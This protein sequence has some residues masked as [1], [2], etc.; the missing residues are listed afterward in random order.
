ML[1]HL[2]HCCLSRWTQT[3]SH[4][5][6][7]KPLVVNCQEQCENPVET[8]WFLNGLLLAMFLESLPAAPQPLMA[9][10]AHRAVSTPAKSQPP[11]AREEL[12]RFSTTVEQMILAHITSNKKTPRWVSWML[13]SCTWADPSVFN[14]SLNSFFSK[15]ATSVGLRKSSDV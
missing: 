10:W 4:W 13:R 12:R 8:M 15:C 1:A 11:L 3:K 14:H 6:C 9:P 2:H 5:G 7:V